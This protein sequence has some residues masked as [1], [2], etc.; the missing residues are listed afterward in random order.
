MLRDAEEHSKN[1]KPLFLGLRKK[2]SRRRTLSTTCYTGVRRGVRCGRACYAAMLG[3]SALREHT[4]TFTLVLRYGRRVDEFDANRIY[5]ALG[6]TE[7][8]GC[9]VGQINNAV[10]WQRPAIVDADDYRP[11]ILQ[12]CNLDPGAER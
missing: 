11:V 6:H 2:R 12:V 9:A 5:P 3:L 8:F 1:R 4:T 10:L 7:H